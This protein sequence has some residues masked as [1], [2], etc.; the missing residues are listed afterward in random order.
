MGNVKMILAG[1]EFTSRFSVEQ[2]ETEEQSQFSY[3]GLFGWYVC[4]KYRCYKAQTQ[5]DTKK[6]IGSGVSSIW[7]GESVQWFTKNNSDTQVWNLSKRF[8]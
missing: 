5:Q 6:L 1:N 4:E 8:Q 2:N 7:V 3:R